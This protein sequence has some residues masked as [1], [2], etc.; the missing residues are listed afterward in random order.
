MIRLNSYNPINEYIKRLQKQISVEHSISD[1]KIKYDNKC[2]IL[3]LRKE[4]MQIT[5]AEFAGSYE[6]SEKGILFIKI[7]DKFYEHSI[8]LCPVIEYKETSDIKL[9]SILKRMYAIIEFGYISKGELTSEEI[10]ICENIFK[11]LY[12]IS[13]KLKEKN[14]TKSIER[15]NNIQKN[16][17]YINVFTARGIIYS[18][19]EYYNSKYCT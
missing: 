15:F 8:K 19:Y 2:F 3:N 10:D 13:I 18:I 7:S 1:V 6:F 11:S 5:G 9:E 4:E 17:R 14:I 12:T 16:N